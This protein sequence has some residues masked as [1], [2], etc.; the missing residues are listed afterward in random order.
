MINF[1][2]ILRVGDTTAAMP[3]IIIK[4]RD[5]DF[6][7]TYNKGK[8]RLDRISFNIYQD[9]TYWSVILMANPE[10]FCEYDIP[11]ETVIRVPFPLNDVIQELITKVN[12]GKFKDNIQ[13]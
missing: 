11:D 7:V 9:E 4:K 6:F 8:T 12:A 3:P 2:Q 13:I 5:T 10:Y 1:S